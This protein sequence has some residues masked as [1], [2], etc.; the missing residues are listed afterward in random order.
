M[1][2]EAYRT[3]F[4]WRARAAVHRFNRQLPMVVTLVVL[5]VTVLWVSHRIEDAR[6]DEELKDTLSGVVQVGAWVALW[7]AISLLFESGFNTL[8]NYAA[9]RRLARMP[10]LFRYDAQ[11][12]SGRRHASHRSVN[13]A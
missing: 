5:G 7:S 2:I 6:M 4:L 8:G 11:L 3:M 1:T 12:T 13:P 10:V 9:F